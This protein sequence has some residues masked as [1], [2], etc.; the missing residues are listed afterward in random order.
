MRAKPAPLITILRI[1][2]KKKP[3]LPPARAS[4]QAM[5]KILS[6][7]SEIFLDKYRF[8]VIINETCSSKM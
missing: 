4:P 5:G 1:R 3:S 2:A 6:I 8:P 7:V